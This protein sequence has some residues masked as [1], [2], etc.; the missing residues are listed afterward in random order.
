MRIVGFLILLFALCACEKTEQVDN[1]PK[2]ESKLVVNCFFF[3][4]TFI[5]V[6]LTK[7]LSP[8]D[9]AAYPFLTSNKA[10]IRLFEDNILFDSL[11]FQTLYYAGN[12]SKTPRA[13]HTYRLECLYPGYEWVSAEDYIPD[14][15]RI[16]DVSG[17]NTILNTFQNTDTSVYGDFKTT[18]TLNL[19]ALQTV[20]KF[21]IIR[22]L[23]SYANQPSTRIRFPYYSNV[24]S[25]PV[26]ETSG[27]NEA[28]FI[29]HALYVRNNNGIKKL[30]LNLEQQYAYLNK[31]KP[32][33]LY[34]INLQTCSEAAYEYQKRSALQLENQNDPFSQPTQISNNIKNGFGIFGGVNGQ[35]YFIR[36]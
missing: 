23:K 9:N 29:D 12:R 3:P 16:F 25:N 31:A 34:Q 19:Q 27:L 8:I 33:Y 36:L 13:N 2:H 20:N 5:K 30:I 32:T 21:M 17:Y 35:T 14:T 28:D 7:S 22:V 24:W 1:Y 6:Y 10:T 26:N 4:D 18:I 15:V 11:K